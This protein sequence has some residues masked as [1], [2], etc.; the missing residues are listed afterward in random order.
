MPADD[1]L[2]LLKQLKDQGYDFKVIYEVGSNIGEWSVN[3]QEIFPD[4][5]FDLFEPLAGQYADM[6]ANLMTSR[7]RDADLHPVALCDVEGIGDIKIL[8][9]RGQ[10]SSILVHPADKKREDFKVVSCKLAR[11]DQ[12][13]ERNGLQQPDFLKLDTQASELKVLKGAENT[14]KNAKFI[15]VE[16]WI[17]RVY[18]QGTPLFQEIA[19]WLYQRDFMIYDMIMTDAG[20]DADGTLRWLDVVYINKSASKFPPALL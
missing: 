1:H 3:V 4:A 10:G 18:G 11:M 9:V 6:D 5:R 15:L 19:D 2:P 20:R 7:L 8:D 14:I 17:R 13:V 16:T 12:Y